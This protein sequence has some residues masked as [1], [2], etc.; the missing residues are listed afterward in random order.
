MRDTILE[1]IASAGGTTEPCTEATAISKATSVDALVF[2]LAND[3]NSSLPVAVALTSDPRT[4]WMPRVVV[5]GEA[6]S[7]A[8]VAPFCPATIVASNA[9]KEALTEALQAIVEQVRSRKDLLDAVQTTIAK[10]RAFDAQVA[11]IERAG[12][13]LSHDARVLFGIILGFAS[14]LRDGFVGPITDEQKNSLANIVQAS[15]DA[16]ALLD[17]YVAGLRKARA[18][19]GPTRQVSTRVATRRYNDLGELVRGTVGLFVGAASER[20]IELR[21]DVPRAI[22]AW[23]DAMQVKQALVNLVSNALKFTPPGGRIE[24]IA[25]FDSPSSSHDSASARR[26]IEIVVTDTGPGI[27]AADRERIFER[28]VRLDRD[29]DIAGTGIGLAIVRDVMDLHGGSVR[30]DEAPGGG[31]SIALVFPVDRR[32]RSDERR[33]SRAPGLR[34]R[35]PSRLRHLGSDSE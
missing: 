5:V 19:S 12:T 26:E 28:G 25:R 15:N 23:C 6:V 10:E 8:Q 32:A 7:A 17:E 2:N 14:N 1:A 16:T 13:A 18:D 20:K 27:P 34:S 22:H 11:A 24:V 35:P 4:R 29:H 21:A 31:A 3:T 33:P 9:P 30:V